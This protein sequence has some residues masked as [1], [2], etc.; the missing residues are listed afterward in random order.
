MNMRVV[1]RNTQMFEERD[2]KVFVLSVQA[3]RELPVGSAVIDSLGKV[4]Q[5]RKDGKWGDL[6]VPVLW[7]T[8]NGYLELLFVPGDGRIVEG[9]GFCLETESKLVYDIG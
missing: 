6:P 9:H 7:E 3:M 8:A 4:Y 1:E 2:G 5:K